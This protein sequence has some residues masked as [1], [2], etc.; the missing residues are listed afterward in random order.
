M[1]FAMKSS[2]QG[3]PQLFQAL[4]AINKKV[5]RQTLRKA[6]KEGAKIVLNDAK[7][8]VPVD[9][10]L[11]KKSLAVKVATFKGGEGVVGI[12]GPRTGK[13]SSGRGPNR[14]KGL[15]KLGQ[16]FAAAERWPAK[17]AH[18]V[19]FGTRGQRTRKA[20]IPAENA[21]RQGRRKK[22][23][24]K[25]NRRRSRERRGPQPFLRPALDNNIGTVRA[26]IVSR[27]Q[28][29]LRTAKA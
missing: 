18:L 5:A 21:G 20:S 3:A 26:L 15:S 23:R 29:A 27:L 14:K 10:G 17:Y 4:R 1:P 24:G 9:T 13:T 28:E 16:K 22:Q 11:L 7:A 8:N 19:E 12:V 2:V 25:K 6:V